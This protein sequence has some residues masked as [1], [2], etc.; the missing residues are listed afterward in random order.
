MVAAN[1]DTLTN[2]ALIEASLKMLVDGHYLR[3]QSGAIGTMEPAKMDAIGGY[4]FA[5]NFEEMAGQS[6]KLTKCG[7]STSDTQISRS[8]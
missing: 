2:P 5:S 6:K 3:S 4:L 1:K 7:S 8:D